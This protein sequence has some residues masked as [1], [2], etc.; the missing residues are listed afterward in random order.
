MSDPKAMRVER[1]KVGA[2][3]DRR[4]QHALHIAHADRRTSISVRL[5]TIA[6]TSRMILGFAAASKASSFTLN[7]VFSF[8]FSYGRVRDI[9]IL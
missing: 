9:I 1:W 7:T 6:L 5:G 3:G 2:E 4:E 8:G